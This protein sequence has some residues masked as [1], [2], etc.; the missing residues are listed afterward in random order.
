MNATTQQAWDN[1][2]FCATWSRTGKDQ[3][4]AVI[5]GVTFV[6]SKAKGGWVVN[7]SDGFEGTDKTFSKVKWIAAKH[8]TLAYL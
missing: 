6:A 1:S 3:H 4:T 2:P 7:G 8:F 5:G